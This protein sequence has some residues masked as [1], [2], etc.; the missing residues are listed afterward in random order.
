M[1]SSKNLHAHTST[2]VASH[3]HTHTHTRQ[4]TTP[5]RQMD[6]N[7]ILSSRYIHWM[8]GTYTARHIH[9]CVAVCG[10][11]SVSSLHSF[12]CG[13]IFWYFFPAH[14]WIGGIPTS[15]R[16]YMASSRASLSSFFL[17]MHLFLAF[18]ILRI[19]IVPNSFR[20]FPSFVFI[21]RIW[22]VSVWMEYWKLRLI[23]R[24]SYICWAAMVIRVMPWSWFASRLLP[25][26]TASPLVIEESFN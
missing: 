6:T 13:Y 15:I 23:V 4:W 22:S 19:R 20:F 7:N 2:T 11:F 21:S 18:L 3:I 12:P 25:A 10:T 5:C 16:K 26:R 8:P 1:I 24:Y 14:T 17:F 9:D